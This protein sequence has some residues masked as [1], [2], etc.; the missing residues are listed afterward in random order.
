MVE[1]DE[2]LLFVCAAVGGIAVARFL[3]SVV[4]FFYSAFLSGGVNV[5]KLGSWAVVT[6]RCSRL[7][8]FQICCLINSF[9]FRARRMESG[10]Q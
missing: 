8:C 4:S 5:K 9:Y 7:H 10:N 1:V 6:V 3:Y 2:T